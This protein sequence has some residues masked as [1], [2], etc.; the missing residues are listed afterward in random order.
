MT[1]VFSTHDPKVV[2]YAGRS[3]YLTD[4]EI[5]DTPVKTMHHEDPANA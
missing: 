4:G 3:L 1:F 2:S 5:S